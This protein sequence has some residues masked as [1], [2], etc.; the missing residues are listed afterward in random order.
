[1]KAKN[2]RA[3][4]NEGDLPES[5]SEC[6]NV[7]AIQRP[8]DPG[9]VIRTNSLKG[10]MKT[11]INVC[12]SEA[13]TEPSFTNQDCNQDVLWNVPHGLG[14]ARDEHAKRGDRFKV[15]DFIIHPNTLRLTETNAALKK[16]MDELAVEG[17]MK[18]FNVRLDRKGLTFPEMTYKG[19]ANSVGYVEK[20]TTVAIDGETNG[21]KQLY[22]N[23]CYG[24]NMDRNG[25][26]CQANV[27]CAKENECAKNENKWIDD[28]SGKHIH[29]KCD[30]TVVSM[31]NGDIAV[32]EVDNSSV[33]TDERVADILPD[34]KSQQDET[35]MTFIFAVER[36]KNENVIFSVVSPQEIC[37]KMKTDSEK[38]FPLRYTCCLKFSSKYCRLMENGC[39]VDVSDV[40]VVLT[41]AKAEKSWKKWNTYFVGTSPQHLEV[42][43]QLN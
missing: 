24:M 17:V 16:V 33:F 41:L 42:S 36:V 4:G 1:M 43:N 10:R 30:G 11:F 6:G 21:L 40:N 3:M 12:Q 28:S 31:A 2:K 29:D 5:R 9:Y 37:L 26:N 25:S 34:Y 14:G 39:H 7:T 35:T 19:T 15:F 22:S 38:G 13:I 32:K 27:P 23:Q 8:V 20:V 18:H